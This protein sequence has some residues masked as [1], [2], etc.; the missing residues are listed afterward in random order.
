MYI[1]GVKLKKYIR[2]MYCANCG[3]PVPANSKFCPECGS[4]VISANIPPVSPPPTPQNTAPQTAAQQGTAPQTSPQQTATPKKE[5]QPRRHGCLKIGGIIAGS[6]LGTIIL[7]AIIGFVA[8][9]RPNR[10]T[11]PYLAF[12]FNFPRSLNVELP[13]TTSTGRENPA[14]NPWF[15]LLRNPTY[16]NETVNWIITNTIASTGLSEDQFMTELNND[17]TSGAAS[18]QMVNGVKMYKYVNDP[19]KPSQTLT[20]FYQGTGMDSTKEQ[21]AYFFIQ[22][23]SFFVVGFRQPPTGA[24]AGYSDYLDINSWKS[25]TLKTTTTTSSPTTSISGDIIAKQSIGASGGTITVNKPGNSLDGLQITVPSG[26][27]TGTRTFQVSYKQAP[28][29]NIKDFNVISPL[30]VID[31]GGSFANQ[32]ITVKIPV[33][34]ADDEFAMAFYYDEKTGQLEGI[35]PIAEDANSI[36]IATCHFSSAAVGKVKKITIDQMFKDGNGIIGTPFTPGED[37]WQ[38]PNAGSYITPGGECAGMS[39]T[40]LWYF[41]EVSSQG[42][43]PRLNGLYAGKDTAPDFWWDD[44]PAYKLPAVVQLDY[45]ALHSNL[46]IDEILSLQIRDNDSLV[47]NSFAVSMY[48]TKQPQLIGMSGIENGTTNRVSHSMVVWQMTTDKLYVVDPNEPE[49]GWTIPYN[50]GK[51]GTLNDTQVTWDRFY[52]EAKSAFHPW[53]LVAE[54]WK[55]FNAGTIGNS[56]FPAYS[57][58]AADGNGQTY[59]LKDNLSINTDTMSLQITSQAGLMI[60]LYQNNAWV[61]TNNDGSPMVQQTWEDIPLNKGDNIIGIY[62]AGEKQVENQLTWVWDDFK[63]VDIQYGAT[64]TTTKTTTWLR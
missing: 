32:P 15:I 47:F 21:S 9:A 1:D 43:G 64:T 2:H 29:L 10:Y 23:G 4:Q 35:P 3:K 36:T 60:S 55:E 13:N 44:T 33:K 6:V 11:H 31:N 25:P 57:L 7:L 8:I 54:R 26:A 46:P 12:S 56:D 51:F 14:N 59:S 39:V 27:Y 19:T 53:D 20:S 30:I 38:F 42:K 62:V 34:I 58:T 24:A 63:W 45:Q 61:R 22:N 52:Y 17:V 16:Q 28:N 50:N 40:S 49:G 18:V 37:N 48:F 41:D 5:K